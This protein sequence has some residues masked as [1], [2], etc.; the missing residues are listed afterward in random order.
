MPHSL[1]QN[2]WFGN[3]VF[4]YDSSILSCTGIA[5]LG[6]K[7]VGELVAL[8]TVRFCI[9]S[10]GVTIFGALHIGSEVCLQSF[11]VALPGDYFVTI[12]T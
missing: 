3:F 7:R 6:N 12:G 4:F 9:R 5:S 11:V 2:L 10:L 1:F 8:F